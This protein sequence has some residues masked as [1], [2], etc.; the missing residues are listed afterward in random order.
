MRVLI[1]RMLEERLWRRREG[2]NS[3]LE[4]TMGKVKS[5][6]EKKGNTNIEAEKDN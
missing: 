6:R 4:R 5:K 1:K 2:I 3:E